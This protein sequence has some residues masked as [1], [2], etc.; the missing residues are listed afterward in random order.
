MAS[1]KE[2]DSGGILMK[3]VADLRTL[4]VLESKKWAVLLFYVAQHFM[5][6]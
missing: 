6:V 2:E 1:V 5:H 3:N 4:G